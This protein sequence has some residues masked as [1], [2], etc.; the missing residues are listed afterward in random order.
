MTDRPAPKFADFANDLDQRGY[1][2]LEQHRFPVEQGSIA[3]YV[4]RRKS[5]VTDAA[6]TEELVIRHF[7]DDAYEI[8]VQR[9]ERTFDA[10]RIV[11]GVP[12]DIKNAIKSGLMAERDEFDAKQEAY[13]DYT[14]DEIDHAHSTQERATTWIESEK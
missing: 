7:P 12:A 9:C 5:G 13:R 10:A 3:H 11:E 1:S 8:F 14:Q 4:V 2:L 6:A